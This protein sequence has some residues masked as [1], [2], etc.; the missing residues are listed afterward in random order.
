MQHDV[1]IKLYAICFLLFEI[2]NDVSLG[3]KNIYFNTE[4]KMFFLLCGIRVHDF[5]PCHVSFN[6]I[7][8]VGLK[9]TIPARVAVAKIRSELY[10]SME[11]LQRMLHVLVESG[12][13]GLVGGESSGSLGIP[14]RTSSFGRQM[15]TLERH[16][17]QRE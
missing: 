9:V 10:S 15:N 8:I 3:V 7:V 4:Y 13:R 17:M 16:R 2:K 14:S 5:R 12:R 1:V 11:E 6:C